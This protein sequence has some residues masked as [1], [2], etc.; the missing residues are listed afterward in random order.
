MAPQPFEETEHERL[1]AA[2]K[3]SRSGTWRWRISD[4]VVEWDEA[5]CDV[6]G[7]KYEQAPKTSQAF[8]ELIHPD[9]RNLALTKI[10]E[11]V[12]S[13]SDAD[14]Q[15][16]VK[17]GERV[18]W[19]YDRSALVRDT[20]GKPA[21][22]LGACLDVTDSRRVLEERDA[23]LAK[24]TLLLNELNHRVKNHLA[25]IIGLLRLKGARQK[26]AAAKEDFNRAIERITV[27][28]YLHDQLYRTGEVDKVDLESYLGDICDKLEQ[29][30]LA[31]SNVSIVRELRPFELLVDRAVPL[32]LIVNELTTNAIKYGFDPGGQGRIAIRLRVQAGRATLTISDNG[33]GLGQSNITPGVGMKL[34]RALAQQIGARLRVVSRHGV[35]CSLSF[36]ARA[37]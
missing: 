13:G 28:A 11:C 8:L 33:R 7:I 26:D 22:M 23:A 24:Q 30:L 20:N 32:G 12:E 4:D 15:F 34:V 37:E 36:T 2:L 10:R 6:Y 3:A 5:L 14:Y 17:I 21:Y 9:D 25:M 35:T 16:R 31:E 1:I 29:S 27:I 19:I 18:R